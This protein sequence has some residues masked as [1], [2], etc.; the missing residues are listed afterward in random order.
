MAL[1]RLI[2][3]AADLLWPPRCA[4]CDAPIRLA[5]V[6]AERAA[7]CEACSSSLVRAASPRC[8]RCGLSFEADGGDHLCGRCLAEPPPFE[9]LSARYAYGGALSAAITRF[10]YGPAPWLAAPLARLLAEGLAHAGPIDLVVP[11]PLHPR[12]LRARGFNQAALLASRLPRAIGA[13]LDTG[14]L[15]REVDTPHQA[16]LTAARRRDALAGVFR[17]RPCG[18]LRGAR[19]LLV[20]DVATTTATVRSA[21]AALVAA[22][23]GA[24]SVLCLARTM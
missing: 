8:P 16:G 1:L 21:A 9:S 5:G 11:V 7:F 18:R 24:V 17:A 13:P 15:R 3:S 10:K 22:G 14:L 12:R 23:A 4:A 19:V 20:D 6:D 2:S